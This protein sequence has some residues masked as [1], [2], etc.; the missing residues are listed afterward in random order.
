MQN[1]AV[2][3]S[4]DVFATYV[5]RQGIQGGNMS[6]GATFDVLNSVINLFFICVSNGLAR[7]YSDT[8][9]W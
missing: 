3:F 4:T 9:L 5:Y 6:Y 1:P 7:R 8:S 2:Q